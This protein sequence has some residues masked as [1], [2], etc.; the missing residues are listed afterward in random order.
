[1]NTN[2]YPSSKI[3]ETFRSMHLRFRHLVLHKNEVDA[4]V[5]IFLKEKQA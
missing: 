3:R 2:V 1:M 5:T 4:L